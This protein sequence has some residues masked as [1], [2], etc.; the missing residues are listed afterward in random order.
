MADDAQY[1]AKLQDY[2]AKH[3]MLPSYS[4]IGALVGL[5][6]KAS[7]AE[8]AKRLKAEGFL[9]SAPDRRLKPGKRFFE[10]EVAESVRAGMPSPAAD[11]RPD[12]ISITGDLG[13]PLRGSHRRIGQLAAAGFFVPRLPA[14]PQ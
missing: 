14:A 2:Y 10:R 12:G 1:L 3:R 11:T 9:D 5:S 8:M 6:S 4:G 13:Q 7:V